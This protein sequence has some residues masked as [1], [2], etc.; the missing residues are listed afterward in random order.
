MEM[1]LVIISE[2]S[3]TLK[4]LYN[5]QLWQ[6]VLLLLCKLCDNDTIK[7][8]VQCACGTQ[9]LMGNEQQTNVEAISVG[10]MFPTPL[11]SGICKHNP[12]P[13][14]GLTNWIYIMN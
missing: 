4:V 2:I 8:V 14:I 3:Y 6:I 5:S 10:N 13:N 12:Y 1:P 11:S 7:E 9:S